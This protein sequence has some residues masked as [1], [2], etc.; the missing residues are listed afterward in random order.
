MPRTQEEFQ[1]TV[2]LDVAFV[3]GEKNKRVYWFKH[4]IKKLIKRILFGDVING[5]V[6]VGELQRVLFAKEQN[7]Y[8]FFPLCENRNCDISHSSL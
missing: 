4:K 7:L 5:V 2:Q 3:Y 1:I 6:I 8:S